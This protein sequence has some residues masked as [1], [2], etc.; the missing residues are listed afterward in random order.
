MREPPIKK[1]VQ[2]L[3]FGNGLSTRFLTRHVT[4]SRKV[5]F[6]IPPQRFHTHYR[7]AVLGVP[8]SYPFSDTLSDDSAFG[9]DFAATG[10]NS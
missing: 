4:L 5:R 1:R 2:K 8:N 7:N 10:P 9:V 6:P 3:A